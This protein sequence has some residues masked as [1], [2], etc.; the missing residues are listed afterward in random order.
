VFESS[1]C[2]LSA[3]L[4]QVRSLAVGFTPTDGPS[5]Y[6]ARPPIR[7]VPLSRE[8][9]GKT[10][11]TTASRNVAWYSRNLGFTI[12][13]RFD[14]DGTTFV[15]LTLRRNGQASAGFPTRASG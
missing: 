10:P 3:P 15:Y 6:T 5:L 13:K 7:V 9:C 12:D 11:D 14:A 1:L 8:R 4:S 2:L